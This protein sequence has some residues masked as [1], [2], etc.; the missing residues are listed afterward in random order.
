MFKMFCF[1][2]FCEIDPTKTFNGEQNKFQNNL[3][4]RQIFDCF[5]SFFRCFSAGLFVAIARFTASHTGINGELRRLRKCA[6]KAIRSLNWISI[7]FNLSIRILPCW[8]VFFTSRAQSNTLS[9]FGFS[10]FLLLSSSAS[11]NHQT[12]IHSS[13]QHPTKR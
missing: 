5:E 4:I 1:G 13:K 6:E 12:A 8:R 11:R 3:V 2:T 9:R 10:Y 7:N